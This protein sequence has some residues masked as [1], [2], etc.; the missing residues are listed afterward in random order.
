MVTHTLTTTAHHDQQESCSGVLHCLVPFDLET[1][2]TSSS[3]MRKPA[4][5]CLPCDARSPV[6]VTIY[7]FQAPASGT[8]E[9]ESQYVSGTFSVGAKDGRGLAQLMG[10]LPLKKAD[11]CH[12]GQ[13][14]YGLNQSM[15]G[16][17]AARCGPAA[18]QW[19]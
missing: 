7:S 8:L 5:V 19:V 2:H 1:H 10:G 12:N 13:L 16:I 4:H 6:V 11:P 15:T 17:V 14:T 9:V 18:A 3:R